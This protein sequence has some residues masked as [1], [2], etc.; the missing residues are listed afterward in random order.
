MTLRK[1]ALLTMLCISVSLTG[2]GTR[3]VYVRAGDPVRLARTIPAAEIWARDSAGVWTRGRVDLQ[4]GWYC[5][6]DPEAPQ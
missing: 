5:L 2:C 6:S 3:T 1:M 4:E